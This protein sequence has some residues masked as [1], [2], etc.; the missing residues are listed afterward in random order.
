[1]G[2]RE[3]T[4]DKARDALYNKINISVKAMMPNITV[5]KKSLRGEAST[6]KYQER[7]K[8]EKKEES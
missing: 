8:M 1:M 4:H 2:S 6:A 7:K 3:A 5:K